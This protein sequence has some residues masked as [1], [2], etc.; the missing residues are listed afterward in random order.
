MEAELATLITSGA[1]TAVGLMVTE[2]WEQAK[3]RVLRVFAR[4]GDE[5]AV[6]G[7]LERSRDALIAAA[8]SPDEEALIDDVTALLR[9]R[10]RALLRH[11][12]D[13]VTELRLLVEEFA[14]AAEAGTAGTAA[15]V[16][17]S[18][19][20]GTVNGPVFQG[21]SFTGLTFHN[22]YDPPQDAPS[23]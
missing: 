14:P 6:S 21:H 1:T 15:T 13:A 4:G 9:L 11:D 18:I 10:L 5:A 8:G 7:E 16:H 20:G 22:T 2:T 19:T 17:N 23:D 3:Q 12:S